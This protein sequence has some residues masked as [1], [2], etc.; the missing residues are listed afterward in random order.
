MIYRAMAYVSANIPKIAP[1]V[2][3]AY[4]EG[5]TIRDNM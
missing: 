5:L 1:M 4:Q 2:F 3:S